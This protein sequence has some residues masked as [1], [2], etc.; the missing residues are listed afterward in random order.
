MPTR[1]SFLN[2]TFSAS[3][4][5]LL[6]SRPA[7][8]AQQAEVRNPLCVFTKPFNSLSA[9]ELARNTAQLGFD[10][11]EAPIRA[12]GHIEPE[13]VAEHLPAFVEALGRHHQ[14]LMVMTSDIND[15]NDELS[16]TVLKTAAVLGVRFYRM[17]Y[18][19]YDENRSITSQITNWNSQLKDLAALNRE[20]GIT[21]VYQNHAGRDYFGA[22]IWDMHRALDGID[23][24]H[25]GVAYDIRHATVEGG[26]SW[27][28]GFQ[29]IRPHVQ[30]VYVKDFDWGEKQPTNV[31]LG[32]GRVDSKFFRMLARSEFNGP[33]SL[34]EEYLD[35]RNPELVPDHWTAIASDLKTLKS[36][37]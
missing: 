4:S 2:A 16:Q 31:P 3:A 25:V 6:A 22:A 35:H 7:D 29:L 20:L 13:A 19:R 26:T 34:H 14:Q 33:V 24:A 37:L 8:A 32:Q 23:P 5:L 27:P 9:N 11:V 28:I 30:V 21:G 15:P 36:W 10:G 1:R 18:F 12:G 17:K